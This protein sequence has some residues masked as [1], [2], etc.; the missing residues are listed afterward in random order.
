HLPLPV[1]AMRLW[2]TIITAA[3]LLVAGIVLCPRPPANVDPG[4]V[5]AEALRANQPIASAPIDD[6][7]RELREH[8]TPILEGSDAIAG[9]DAW[10]IRL[11]P[12]HR[13][14]PWL[15]VWIDKRTSAVIAWK[16]WGRRNGRVTV[17][18]QFPRP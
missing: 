14:Y 8:C 10:A 4:R 3:A 11:K 9:H 17:L 1:V 12:P 6:I 18:R 13:K 5:L 2:I 7:R 16:E 15:E